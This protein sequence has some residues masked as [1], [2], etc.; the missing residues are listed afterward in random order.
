MSESGTERATEAAEDR[1]DRPQ[2]DGRLARGGRF[3]AFEQPAAFVDELRT[4]F[5]TVR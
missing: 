1:G 3:A 2:R 4:F 5:R